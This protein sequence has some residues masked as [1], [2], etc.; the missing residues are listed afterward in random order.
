MRIKN[1]FF[2][3]DGVIAES[4]NI[5]TEAFYRIYM[6]F[7]KDIA[8]KAVVHHKNNGGMSR[9]EKFKLY[10]K[11]FLGIELSKAQI[12][13]F[14]A[15][16]SDFVKQGV[17]DAPDVPGVRPFLEKYS[18]TMKFWIV[19]G[20]PTGEIRDIVKKK[21][22]EPYFIQ[23][24]GSPEKKDYWVR[25]LMRKHRLKKE[26]SLFVGDAAADH[27]A[28]VIN[29][30]HFVLRETPEGIPVFRGID[31]PRFSVFSEFQRILETL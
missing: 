18:E 10:H 13:E 27:N 22:M 15:R 6:E 2:D 26:E 19:S 31:V 23:C 7:G 25:E 21:G 24:F 28:A 17:I 1:I 16:F 14:S 30:I 3:F 4:V 5:K 20:T 8:E 12:D 11:E 9:Y 29:G